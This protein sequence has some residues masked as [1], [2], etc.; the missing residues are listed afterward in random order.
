VLTEVTVIDVTV[1]V[2][3]GVGDVE[4]LLQAGIKKRSEKHKTTEKMRPI[5]LD[6]FSN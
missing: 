5:H 6:G 1:T 4:L 3:G 2:V